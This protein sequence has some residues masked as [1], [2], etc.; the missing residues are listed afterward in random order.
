[1]S[2]HFTGGDINAVLRT[3]KALSSEGDVQLSILLYSL[4][5]AC[6]S[7]GV[8]KETLMD[9]LWKAFDDERRLVQLDGP[10]ATARC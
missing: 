10:E 6:K 5:T 7:C 2:G 4:V 3:T 8:S 1:M 9:E